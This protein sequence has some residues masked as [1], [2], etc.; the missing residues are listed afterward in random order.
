MVRRLGRCDDEGVN[1]TASSGVYVTRTVHFIELEF[2]RSHRV[3]LIG[4]S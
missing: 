1:Y 4:W 2:I 3:Q